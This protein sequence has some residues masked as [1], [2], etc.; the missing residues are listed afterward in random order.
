M[1]P[2]S[3]ASEKSTPPSRNSISSGHSGSGI[4]ANLLLQHQHSNASSSYSSTNNTANTNTS[5]D[6]HNGSTSSLHHVQQHPQQ[7]QQH[8]QQQQHQLHLAAGSGSGNSSSGTAPSGATAPAH[9]TSAG[10]SAALERAYVHDVYEHCEEPHAGP[11]RPRVAQFLASLEPGSMVC[12][13]GCGNGRYLNANPLCYTL[14]VERCARLAAGVRNS[15]GNSNAGDANNAGGGG[16]GGGGRNEV[17]LCDNLELPFRDECFDAVLSVAVVHHF[18]TTERRVGAIRELARVLRIGG[19]VIITVWALEQS[20]R[21]F[22]SQDV[23]IPWQQ[24]KSRNSNFSDEGKS[25]SLE[26]SS[27]ANHF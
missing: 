23:L 17:A 9:N 8:P 24:P 2:S 16:G 19:R 10:R 25:N 22:E 6:P 12:D 1:P 26:L 20:K 5:S 18:A 15:S 14:G 11:V 21:R 4:I 27:Y 7:Q 13:V 3:A